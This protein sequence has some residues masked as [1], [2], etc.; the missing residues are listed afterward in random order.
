M[1]FWSNLAGY[2]VVWFIT[3]IGAGRGLAWPALV[4]AFCFISWQIL[5]SDKPRLECKLLLAAV[6][7]GACV[8]GALAASGWAHYAA[9]TLALPV[10]GAPIWILALWASFS[11]TLT[12]S[13]KYLVGRPWIALIFGAAGAP[14]AYLSAA[15]GWQALI[16]EQPLWHGVLILAVG[17]GIAL[18]LLTILAHRA[19]Q[20]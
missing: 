10:G 12:Q 4:A 9:S 19:R 7:F 6:L 8:D 15:G 16:F 11:M 17:W 20:D 5:T 18:P 13:L 2:Q 14:L 1:K 3:V